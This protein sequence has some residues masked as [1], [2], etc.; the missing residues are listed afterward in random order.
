MSVGSAKAHRLQGDSTGGGGGGG[1]GDGGEGGRCG[2]ADTWR[3]SKKSGGLWGGAGG[4]GGDGGGVGGAGGAGGRGAGEGML[5]TMSRT[6]SDEPRNQSSR[7]TYGGA[8]SKSAS[9]RPKGRRGLPPPSE[10]RVA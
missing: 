5:A 6:S 4:C 3:S 8:A 2:G 7:V 10:A 9:H 1:G